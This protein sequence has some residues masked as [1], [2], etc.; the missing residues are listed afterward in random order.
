VFETTQQAEEWINAKFDKF[1][2]TPHSSLSR[3]TDPTTGQR[4]HQTPTEAKDAAIAAG[5]EPMWMD[6]LALMDLF[7]MHFK[8]RVLRAVVSPYLRQEYHHAD[9]AEVEGQDVVVAVDI[10]DGTRVW[11]KDLGGRLICEAPVVAV[12]GYRAMSFY[13]MSLT[14]RMTAQIKR[15]ENQI[16]VI[17]ERMDPERMPL[18]TPA[19][20]VHGAQVLDFGPRGL[21]PLQTVAETVAEV[22]A[23]VLPE[24]AQALP[25]AAFVTDVAEPQEPPKETPG[26]ALMRWYAEEAERAVAAEEALQAQGD[27][28]DRLFLMMR[29]EQ[30]ERERQEEEAAERRRAMG[31]E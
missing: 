5:F 6:D 3:I 1:N 30:D 14:K 7:R 21:K 9:L 12:T 13:E 8:R 15:K 25:E 29:A 11:V 4:R 23:E 24:S 17:Q 22:V 27:G 16:E 18:E 19:L 20:E 2:N 28:P 10:M 31:G 26:E